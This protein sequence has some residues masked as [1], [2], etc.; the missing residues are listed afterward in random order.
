MATIEQFESEYMS[1]PFPQVA[2]L[3]RARP[4]TLDVQIFFI[5]DLWTT[6]SSYD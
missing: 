5:F 3:L 4:T 1:A 6:R 2:P